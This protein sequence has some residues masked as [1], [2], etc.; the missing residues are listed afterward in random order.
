MK[1]QIRK[2]TLC[3]QTCPR[4][5]HEVK[6]GK[7]KINLSGIKK[8]QSVQTSCLFLTP[9]NTKLVPRIVEQSYVAP[10]R[11][12]IDG[13]FTMLRDRHFV[14]NPRKL[15]DVFAL[16]DFARYRSLDTGESSSD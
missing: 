6:L 9:T 16:F 1:V 5:A 2:I 12:K 13:N 3:I 11:R 14:D 10:S 7:I 8:S 4:C 15:P